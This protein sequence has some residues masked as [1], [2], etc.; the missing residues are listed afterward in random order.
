MKVGVLGLQG[1][2]REHVRAVAAAGATP[3]VVK[4]A[5]E[6]ADADALVL[7]GGESTTIGKL[8]DRFGLLEPLRAR[9]RAGMPL[10]GTCAGLILMARDV[11]GEHDAPHRLGVLDVAVRRNAYGRQ[12]ESFE[13]DLDVA[14][15]DEPF[16]AVFIRAPAIEETGADVEV[17]ARH[18]G[19]PVLVRQ[20]RLLASSFHP[21]LSNDASV[22]ELFVALARDGG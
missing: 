2:V 8:L 5:D 14:G 16:R 12:V 20:G 3:A 22:H 7:P 21:E 1:D 15:R 19:R 6:L 9:A 11:V 10:Y 13:A 18:E 4:R 17:L